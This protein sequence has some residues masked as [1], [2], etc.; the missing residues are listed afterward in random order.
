MPAV[1]ANQIVSGNV[2]AVVANLQPMGNLDGTQQLN[3]A[4]ALPLRNQQGLEELLQQIYD[5]ASANFRQYLTP[6]QFTQSY[7]PTVQDYQAVVAFAQANNL[8]VTYEHSNRVILDVTG[9]VADI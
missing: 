2:P 3:L 5:P 7:G 9:T 4:I 6:E 8:T 1:A